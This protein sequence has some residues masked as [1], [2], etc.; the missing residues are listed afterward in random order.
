MGGKDYPADY[1]A[2][3]SE[4]AAAAREANPELQPAP[5]PQPRDLEAYGVRSG[6]PVALARYLIDQR[7]GH[8]QNSYSLGP[9]RRLRDEFQRHDP[10]GEGCCTRDDFCKILKNAFNIEINEDGWQIFGQKY[11]CVRPDG[12]V[13]YHPFLKE[14][15]ETDPGMYHPQMGENRS[16]IKIGPAVG[17]YG[18]KKD[19]HKSQNVVMDAQLMNLLKQLAHKVEDKSKYIRKVFRCAQLMASSLSCG[20]D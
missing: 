9:R 16:H 3:P 15:L 5:P 1:L 7:S 11:S 12:R 13:N 8:G 17:P 20:G 19:L 4:K 10:A 18:D 6:D 2:M 14:V